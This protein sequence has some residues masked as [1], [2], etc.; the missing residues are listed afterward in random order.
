VTHALL[1]V[2]VQRLFAV[3]AVRYRSELASAVLLAACSPASA[4]ALLAAPA[5]GGA[6]GG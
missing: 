5:R 4:V 1:D 3:H 6:T 2:L